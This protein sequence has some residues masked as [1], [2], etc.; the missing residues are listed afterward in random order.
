[1]GQWHVSK[2]THHTLRPTMSLSPLVWTSLSSLLTLTLLLYYQIFEKYS[3]AS[4]FW[5]KSSKSLE[6]ALQLL[7]LILNSA[8]WMSITKLF[9]CSN[10]S[11]NLVGLFTIKISFRTRGYTTTITGQGSTQA[12]LTSRGSFANSQAS[13]NQHQRSSP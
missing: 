4:G 5:K 6:A 11:I 10:K 1:M 13:P 3:L 7:K 12:A 8:L 9:N 2:P